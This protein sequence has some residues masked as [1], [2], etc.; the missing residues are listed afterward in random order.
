[1]VNKSPIVFPEELPGMPPDRDIEFVIEL[2]PDTTPACVPPV[3]PHR[4]CRSGHT[5]RDDHVVGTH[6]ALRNLVSSAS[7]IQWAGPTRSLLAHLA[8]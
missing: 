1:V 2:K 6:G 4:L 5:V 7:F 8:Q 3:N